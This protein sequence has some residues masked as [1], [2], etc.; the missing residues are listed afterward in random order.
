LAEIETLAGKR[1][2]IDGTAARGGGGFT[3]LANIVSQLCRLAPEVHFRIL[4]RNPQ[5]KDFLGGPPNLEVDLLPEVGVAGRFRFTYLDIP[6]IARDGSADLYFSAGEIAPVGL[7]CPSIASFRNLNVFSTLDQGWSFAERMRLDFLWLIARLTAI[8][9]DRIM[10]VSEDSAQWI[11]DS[12]GLPEDKRVVIHHGIDLEGWGNARPYTGHPRPYMLSVSSVYRYKNFVRLIEAHT[13]LAKK[14]PDLPDLII[15]GDDQD[16][17]YLAQMRAAREAAGPDAERIQILG[18]VSYAD[19]KSYYAGAALFVFPSYL[20][21]F[22]H[23]LLEAMA[24]G[25]PLVASDMPIFREIAADAAVYAD[26]H[27]TASIANAIEDALRPEV[28][29]RLLE[30]GGRRLS[31]FSWER[32]AQGLLEMFRATLAR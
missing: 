16:P 28:T 9:C 2:L 27:D 8:T 6:R 10:F 29:A 4:I 1:I 32:S 19:V 15:I 25:V 31:R 13:R 22:G 14:H 18:E 30:R 3:Y 5:L 20:E 23:P 17:P 21:S 26:P 7:R 12:I 24:A 11:G